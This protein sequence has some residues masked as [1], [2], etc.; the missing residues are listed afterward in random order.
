MIKKIKKILPDEEII[1]RTV[2]RG[3]CPI[4][5]TENIVAIDDY[6]TD[7]TSVCKHYVQVDFEDDDTY[8]MSFKEEK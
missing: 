3:I 5:D 6:C 1:T 7:E 2:L 4:C 8:R